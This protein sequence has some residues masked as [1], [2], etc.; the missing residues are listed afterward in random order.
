MPDAPTDN[1]LATETSPY[2]LQHADNPVPWRPWGEAAFEEARR[3]DVPI[4]LSVGYATCYWC[5]VMER[6]SFAD[7]AVGRAMAERFVCVKVDREQRPDVDEAYMAA[8]QIMTGAGGWPMSVFLEPN[9][10]RPFWCGTYFPPRPAHNRPSFAQVLEGIA[11]AWRDRRGEVLEQA[12]RLA[13]AVEQ[14]LGLTHAARLTV[15]PGAVAKAV[16]SLLSMADRANGGF[17]HAPKFPQPVY[18]DLL[19]TA[20][21]A[22]DGATRSAADAVLRH[23][24]DRMA[25]GGV[26]DQAGGGFHR[27]AVDA[28]W[29]VPHFE[30]MLYDNAL[31]AA[32]YARAARVF[33]DAFYADVAARTLGFVSREM[34][35]P[36]PTGA[37][38]ASALD[39]EVNGREG[40]NYL[41]TPD[42]AASALRDAAA[43][44]EE[45]NAAGV[46]AGD[47][48]LAPA[49]Y[50]LDRPANF[51]DPH[52]PEDPPAWVL[53]MDDRPERLA[54]ALGVQADAIAPARARINAALLAARQ[55]RQSPR[56]DDKALAA[57]NGM[58]LWALARCAV[59]LERPE[60]EADAA[61]IAQFLD[62]H[63]LDAR[64]LPVRSWVAGGDD[65]RGRTTGPGFLEDAAWVALKEAELAHARRHLGLDQGDAARRAAAM[66]D[67]AAQAFGDADRPG[68]CYDTQAGGLFVRGRSTYDGATPC[69]QAVLLHALTSLHALDPAGGHAARAAAILASLSEDVARSPLS[70]CHSTAALLELMRADPAFADR[71]A[72]A[73]TDDRPGHAPDHAPD[74][75][76]TQGEDDFTP[77]EVYA[78]ADRVSVG[79]DT[80][81]AFELVVRIAP[82]YHVYAADPDA[83]GCFP[84]RL[85]ITGGSGVAVY[86]DYPQGERLPAADAGSPADAL[87]A[88]RVYRGEV[89]F[90]VALEQAGPWSGRPLL[91]LAY[92]VC[93]DA[94]C[95]SPRTVELDVAID[96]LADPPDSPPADA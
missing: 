37:A 66:L 54:S 14:S 69:A 18:L 84:L 68:A 82:G 47:A 31:L 77:V 55:L 93:D 2:L 20:R 89:S 21:D 72:Q 70:T 15:G 17:G 61:A 22:L 46:R 43:D 90:T 59:D 25:V 16:A 26:F 86:A 7:P 74:H 41:W 58:L 33:G 51:R 30:K 52:H 71:A 10:G 65:G 29:T 12:R 75:A 19:L 50:G 80:P 73:E 57:W 13:D 83:P 39:A 45:A 4:F 1:R 23:A 44:P 63:M 67:A 92:Q 27:Y 88:P 60:L 34:R 42:E 6:E 78:N 24:L 3:R 40:R 91:T 8:T 96:Q 81:A 95:L 94:R 53:R 85:A 35:L 28:S 38:Y 48:D 79:P 62:A 64:G 76:P 87:P 32:V 11:A 5:H 36:A 56:R 49:L 9:E